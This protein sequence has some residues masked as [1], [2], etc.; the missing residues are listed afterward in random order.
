M[1]D[2]YKPVSVIIFQYLA[3]FS[4]K[5]YTIDL[6]FIDISK[7]FDTID[8]KKLIVKLN[9]YGIRGMCHDGI[10]SCLCN[11]T[12][13]TNF[14]QTVLDTCPIEFGVPQGSILGP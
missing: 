12:Q 3:R 10:K 5:L 7:A 1:L 9:H 4:K 2:N 14:Q 11:R 8:H 13:Y 6:L